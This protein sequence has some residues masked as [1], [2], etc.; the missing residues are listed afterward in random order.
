MNHGAFDAAPEKIEEYRA[1][2]MGAGVDR[3][4]VANHH[5][6]ESGISDELHSGRADR[7]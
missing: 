2:R 1:R 3:T 4:E 7:A 6:S 5:D